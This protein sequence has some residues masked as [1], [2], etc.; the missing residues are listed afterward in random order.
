MSSLHAFI[1]DPLVHTFFFAPVIAL[2]L[3]S[4]PKPNQLSREELHI[5]VTLSTKHK[6]QRAQPAD[7]FV[8]LSALGIGVF[9]V[10]LGY[11][12]YGSDIILACLCIV[13]AACGI[14]ILLTCVAIYRGYGRSASWIL[15]LGTTLIL[16]AIARYIAGLHKSLPGEWTQFATYLRERPNKWEAV[17]AFWRATP[18]DT[19]ISFSSF[20]TGTLALLILSMIAAGR[21]LHL[22]AILKNAAVHNSDLALQAQ[23][24]TS[25]FVGFPAF[26]WAMALA[27]IAYL[28][29]TDSWAAFLKFS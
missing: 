26:V 4:P 15:H 6:P 18:L 5:L 3:A 22:M 10:A 19:I 9:F 11:L 24:V 16:S 17:V 27:L 23:L 21:S 25:N 12:L 20:G 29:V 2:L 28:G 1:Y 8:I 14:A 7:E 13:S